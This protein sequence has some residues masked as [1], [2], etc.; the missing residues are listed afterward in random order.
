MVVKKEYEYIK[1]EQREEAI[2][3][4]TLNRLQAEN[5]FTYAMMEEFTEVCENLREE[6]SCKVL[7]VRAEGP[8][9]SSGGDL[10]EEGGWVKE[11]RQDASKLMWDELRTQQWSPYRQALRDLWESPVI[12]IAQVQGFAIEIGMVFA[13]MCDI[14]IAADDAR[15]FWRPVGGGG[16]LWH[17][18]PW[19]IGL[20]RTKEIL[21]TGEWVTGKE[22]AQMNM[23]NRS[24]PAESLEEE[25]N[26][27]AQKI[28]TKPR[29]FL[30]ADKVAVN[31]AYEMM[32]LYNA[33]DNGVLA[34]VL[35]HESE[36]SQAL[37]KTVR[38]GTTKDMSD[39]LDRRASIFER[40]I[41]GR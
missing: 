6:I 17:L 4:I 2:A 18:W 39:A 8:H 41:L 9:F 36:P 20:R 40:E 25:V 23:I 33:F 14:V 13:L 16:M 15:F 7:I 34:H 29:E 24:V 21:F 35:S 22:A 19:T 5:A 32:G 26:R 30:W 31:K 1:F 38:E 28:A 11:L 10:D 37:D 27:W 3:I 12:S